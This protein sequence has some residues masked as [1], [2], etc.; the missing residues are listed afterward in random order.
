LKNRQKLQASRAKT[1]PKQKH[2]LFGNLIMLTH[3]PNLEG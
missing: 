1:V 2:P 3:L